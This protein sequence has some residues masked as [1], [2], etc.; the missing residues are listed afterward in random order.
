MDCAKLALI[1]HVHEA[2]T[3]F[4]KIQQLIVVGSEAVYTP[5]KEDTQ[6]ELQ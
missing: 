1:T 2:H 6:A 3:K 5:G 4:L